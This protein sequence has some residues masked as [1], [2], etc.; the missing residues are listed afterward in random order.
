MK[1]AAAIGY[2]VDEIGVRSATSSIVPPEFPFMGGRVG[3]YVQERSLSAITDQ[4]DMSQG[5]R[6]PLSSI[7]PM[8]Y[9]V[10]AFRRSCVLVDDIGEGLDFERST[11]LIALLT[12]KAKTSGVQLVM[13]TNDRFVMNS[14]PLEAWTVLRREG[15][16][17][18]IYNYE[19]SK[20]IFD[21]CKLTG[22]NNFD[23]LAVDFINQ[24]KGSSE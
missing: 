2:L 24:S 10:S 3:L 7:T 23:F 19:N 12:R 5:M 13:A 21:E 8:H 14:V 16:R 18:R 22:M 20:A 15:S 4:S 11:A 1:D 17:V 6:R 9:P